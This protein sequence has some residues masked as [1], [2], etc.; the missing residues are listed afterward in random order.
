[1]PTG[2]EVAANDEMVALLDQFNI[3]ADRL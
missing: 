1:V 2:I 3:M